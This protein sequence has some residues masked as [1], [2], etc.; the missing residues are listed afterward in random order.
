MWQLTYS[1]QADNLDKPKKK[2]KMESAANRQAIE[3]ERITTL[4]GMFHNTEVMSVGICNPEN[5]NTFSGNRQKGARMLT[6]GFVN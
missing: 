3:S 1:L 6:D 2:P 5:N 4:F